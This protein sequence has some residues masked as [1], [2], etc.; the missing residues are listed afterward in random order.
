[1]IILFCIQD[2][3]SS[4]HKKLTPEKTDDHK[5]TIQT[6]Q[7]TIHPELLLAFTFFDR[8]RCGYLT[9]KDLEEILL[10]SGLSLTKNEVNKKTINIQI[11]YFHLIFF[12]FQA[13]KLVS[14]IAHNEKVQYHQLTDKALPIDDIN[15]SNHIEINENDIDPLAPKGNL[16]L[17]PSHLSVFG[18]RSTKIINDD[19]QSVINS[20]DN[21]RAIKQ[22]EMSNKIQTGLEL[23]I[24]TLKKE[25]RMF[26]IIHFR[27]TKFLLY[28]Q[29]N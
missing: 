6:R 16:L 7:R 10:L 5:S 15:N 13:K 19:N 24:D 14:H 3:S 27:Y 1:M 28:I 2:D 25:I 11:L 23:K 9:E 18:L 22:L 20:V 4:Q 8:N 29:K 21:Q 12:F 26:N 17:L